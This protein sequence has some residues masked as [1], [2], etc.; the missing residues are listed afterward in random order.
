MWLRSGNYLLGR[1]E[2]K[3][4]SKGIEMHKKKLEFLSC[5]K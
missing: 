1:K 2:Y 4:P 5:I 3:Q